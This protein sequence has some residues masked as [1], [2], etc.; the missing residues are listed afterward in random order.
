MLQINIYYKYLLLNFLLV[1][2]CVNIL[3]FLILRV[4]AGS[5]L[6]TSQASA[7]APKFRGLHFLEIIGSY[8][9]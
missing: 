4:R 7:L 3:K 2:D 5:N 8:V 1:I 6:I 9:F